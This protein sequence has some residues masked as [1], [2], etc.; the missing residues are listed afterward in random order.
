MEIPGFASLAAFS[1]YTK[2]SYMTIRNQMINGYCA[3]PRRRKSNTTKNSAYK[4][5][6]NMIQRCYNPKANKYDIYGV[7]GIN[8]HPIWKSSFMEFITY[9]GPRPSHQHSIDRID[10]NGAYV[11]GNVRWATHKEQN[12]NKRIIRKGKW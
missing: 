3:Y 7:R 4:C 12:E 5:W 1:R 9:I 2:T 11:P 8:V 10:V 6:E